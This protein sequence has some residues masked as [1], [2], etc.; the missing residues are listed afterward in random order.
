M[1]RHIISVGEFN[2]DLLL[3]FIQECAI[4]EG[5][6]HPLLPDRKILATLFFEPST[7]TRLSFESAMA[8]LNG[9]CIG[10]AD[11]K[12]TSV[13]KGETVYD[14]IRTIEKYA[15]AI[16]IRHPLEGVARLA[17]EAVEDRIP[18]I[19]GG[20]GAGEHPTQ[21]MTDLYT[22]YKNF[23][24]LTNLNIG[25]MGDLKYSRTV[26]SL[27][28]ALS[29]LENITHYFIPP[30]ATL[31]LDE[32]YLC[33]LKKNYS[34]VKRLSDV[35]DRLDVLY[36]TR[37]QVER[38]QDPL[39]YNRIM[40]S[41]QITPELLQNRK[42]KM[43]VMHPLPRNDEIH[44]SVDELNCSHYFQ[45]AHNGVPVRMNLLYKLIEEGGLK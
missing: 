38:F 6:D 29:F 44:K 17:A 20:S 28:H 4:F 5:R 22:I 19:N 23:G 7:R 10:F 34:Y 36:V 45:Q 43:I 9:S 3:S 12:S 27:I 24:R 18:V 35:V 40:R 1:L 26:H 16:V 8:R 2:R 32:D 21:A 33:P 13:K 39:E 11:D 15:D 25:Y 37:L 31:E 41:Y 14:S 30:D 42:Q